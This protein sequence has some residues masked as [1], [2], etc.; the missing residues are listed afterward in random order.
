[1]SIAEAAKSMPAFNLLSK[2]RVRSRRPACCS[3]RQWSSSRTRSGTP[4]TSDP[5]RRAG[6]RSGSI[7]AGC[8]RR[9]A[10]ARLSPSVTVYLVCLVGAGYPRCSSGRD[11]IENRQSV[12]APLRHLLGTPKNGRAAVRR[13]PGTPAAAWVPRTTHSTASLSSTHTSR[14][15]RP[16]LEQRPA[17]CW[18]AAAGAPARDRAPAAGYPR[19]P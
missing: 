17:R 10:R 12:C 9:A 11:N 4:G 5:Q 3:W 18:P 6:G 2:E 14:S 7:Y 13:E 16:S 19:R 1:V 8:V 15:T